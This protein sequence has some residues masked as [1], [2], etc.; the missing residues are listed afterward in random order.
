VLDI[1]ARR[2]TVTFALD[3]VLTPGHPAYAEPKPGDAHCYHRGALEFHGVTD[4]IWHESGLTAATDA[5]GEMDFGS[6][7]SYAYEGNEHRLQGEWG[8]MEISAS[9]VTFELED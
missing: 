5:T 1:I 2:G 8:Q 6:I 4:L 3:A 7:D 9:V